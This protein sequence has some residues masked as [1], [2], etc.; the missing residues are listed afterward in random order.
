MVKK[1]KETGMLQV[2]IQLVLLLGF[3]RLGFILVGA[4]LA[5]FSFMAIEEN[6]LDR[7]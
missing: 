7:T 2:T 1:Y 3:Q 4:D 5:R 6:I